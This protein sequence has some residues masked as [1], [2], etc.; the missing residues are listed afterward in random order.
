MSPHR[1]PL[2]SIV[3]LASVFINTFEIV[4]HKKTPFSRGFYLLSQHHLINVE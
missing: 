2:F 3:A 4:W 1:S